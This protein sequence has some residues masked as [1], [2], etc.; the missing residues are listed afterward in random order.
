MY[1]YGPELD[2]ETTA[3]LANGAV[4][5]EMLAVEM[6]DGTIREYLVLDR[7]SDGVVE[8]LKK[9]RRGRKGF[10]LKVQDIHSGDLYAAKLCIPEDYESTTPLTEL[11]FARELRGLGELILLPKLLGSVSRF[12]G[13]PRHGDS[14]R[15]VCFVS[16]WLDGVTLQEMIEDS[17]NEITPGLVAAVAKD[18]L[19]AVLVMEDK[20]Y[21]HDDLNLG[22]LMLES[23]DESIAS[24]NPS[25]AV[26]RLRIIDLGSMKEIDRATTKQDDDWSL[27]A[28]CLVQL[29]NALHS[30]RLL[31]SQYPLFI[32]SFKEF[33]HDLAD[34]P[35]RKFPDRGDYVRRIERAEALITIEPRAETVFHPMEAISA[36]HLVDDAILLELFVR[37]LPWISLVQRPNPCVLVG[38]RGCG[39][40][41]VFRH[42]ATKTHITS[43]TSSAKILTEAKMFGVYIG[44]SSDLSHDLIWISHEPDRVEAYVPRIIDYFNLV[45]ARELMRSL[46]SAASAEDFSKCLGINDQAKRRIGEFLENA[47]GSELR[48]I[49]VSGMEMFQSCA[50]SIER[51]RFSLAQ[52]MRGGPG[53]GL[54]T[55]ATFLRDLCS[56]IVAE[57]P[58]LQHYKITFLLDDYTEHRISRP[59]QEILNEIVFQRV[60]S[61]MFKVSSEPYG[62]DPSTFHGTRVDS[63]REYTEIDAGTDCLEM[64]PPG[65]KKFVSDMLDR[66]LKAAKYAGTSAVLIGESSYKTDPKL[67]E[68]IKFNRRG[69]QTHYN[70]LDVLSNAW[71]GD[72]ATVLHI[73]SNMFA[74]SGIAPGTTTR[75]SNQVQHNAI[76]RVSK[77]L[78]ARVQSF[79]PYGKE[80]GAILSA[81]GDLAARLLIE[82][83]SK[84]T[85]EESPTNRKY[86]IEWTLPEGASVSS[87][88]RRVDA[89]GELYSLYKELVRRAVFHE[90]LESRGKE[91]A[92][93]RIVRLQVRSSL[94][95]SFGT[96]LIRE[97][98]LKIVRVEDFVE[99]LTMPERWAESVIARYRTPA[100]IIDLFG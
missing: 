40:S 94:L 51:L 84:S 14:T 96:S 91:G 5:P 42:M 75:I 81:F 6:R 54:G 47:L 36:E 99:F 31:A 77:G 62:F 100:K 67:A 37:H 70:G 34:E 48:R 19:T 50:D 74:D 15:W 86:R 10:V 18:L 38:P 9:G 8:P 53:G 95:P 90:N 97:N 61:L 71:S 23:P 55:G 3:W 93:R 41:M 24:I 64:L 73:V 25:K 80:M 12:E 21:K 30:N 4:I 79:S 44:C 49:H 22:N 65:R 89:T 72:V 35:S 29:H 69:K 2:P 92:G 76:V 88:L 16:E 17:P 98:H 87:E 82:F 63:T 56:K 28:R 13:E 39:K 7:N 85:G 58:P 26:V 66:R 60:P 11:E 43:K 20:G 1:N 46:A 45:A 68:A 59:I 27:S 33:I 83:D 57:L 52:E 32:K 78:R